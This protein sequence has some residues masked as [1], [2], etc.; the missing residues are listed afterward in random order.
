MSLWARG[1]QHFFCDPLYTHLIISKSLSFSSSYNQTTFTKE[2]FKEILGIFIKPEKLTE[3]EITFHKEQKICLVCKG[4]VLGF[5]S[6]I[7]KCDALYCE[8]CAQTLSDLENA[9]WV[10]EAP[11]DELKPVKLHNEKE[12]LFIVE[13]KPHKKITFKITNK[14][15]SQD[16]K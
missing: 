7:C 5:N 10:C 13:E 11:F 9:C 14:E 12:D 4:K 15:D 1:L 6:F 16:E 8:N 2:E 3:E